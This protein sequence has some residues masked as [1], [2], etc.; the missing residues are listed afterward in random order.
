MSKQ[1]LFVGG[2][3]AVKQIHYLSLYLSI[4]RS[5]TVIAKLIEWNQ[6]Q[7]LESK[8]KHLRNLNDAHNIFDGLSFV[9]KVELFTGFFYLISRKAGVDLPITGLFSA[10]TTHVWFL[11]N[12]IDKTRKPPKQQMKISEN[13]MHGWK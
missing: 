10:I 13:K 7:I 12:V 6:P 9:G 11:P 8:K 4:N 5:S 3:R 1:V 2:E